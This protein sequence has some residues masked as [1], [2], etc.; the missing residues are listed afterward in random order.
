[1]GHALHQVQCGEEPRSAK[2]LKGF[3]G[4][5]VVEIIDNYGGDTFRTI[6]T[7]RFPGLIY[8]LHAFQKKS[9]RGIATPKQTIDL[10]KLRMRQAEEDYRDRQNIRVRE[11]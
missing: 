4:R 8:V 3:G 6:Y 2:A 7:V 10:I 5:S 11:R 9:K 1:M